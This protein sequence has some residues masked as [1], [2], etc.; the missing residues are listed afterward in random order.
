MIS[1]SCL[2]KPP[3]KRSGFSTVTTAPPTAVHNETLR[4]QESK[5]RRHKIQANPQV[6]GPGEAAA[7]VK[8]TDGEERVQ[9]RL[10]ERGLET[11]FGEVRI[12]RAGYVAK[13]MESLHP[14]DA[15]LNL[16]KELYSHE[17]RRRV[18]WTAA[19]NSFD[20]V[21]GMLSETTGAEVG[22]RQVEELVI[23]AAE[24]FDAFYKE[25]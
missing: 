7:P 6:R 12:E 24:D 14:M 1:T 16:P 18:G 2:E 25:G 4:E 22:K 19:G 20:E 10:H 13:G 5:K 21:I 11:V 15:D 9:Q 23:R 3:Q 8:G 17:V